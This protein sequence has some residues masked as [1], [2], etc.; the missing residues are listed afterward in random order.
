[1]TDPNERAELAELTGGQAQVAEAGAFFA[2]CGDQR[3]HQLVAEAAAKPYAP[4]LESFLVA[5]IDASLFAQNLVIA[6]ESL[7]YGTCYIGGLRT[8]IREVDRLLEIPS[9]VFPL[10]GLCVGERAQDANCRDRLPTRA[11]WCKDRYPSDEEVRAFIAEHDRDMAREYEARGLAGRD[12]SGG[13]QRKFAKP[14]REHLAEYYTS[15]GAR[16]E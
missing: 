8:K 7:G 6:F 5:A 4:N 3:R 12:W 10:Y 13:I 1:M 15:K 11:V 16:L 9:G 2:V 14:A